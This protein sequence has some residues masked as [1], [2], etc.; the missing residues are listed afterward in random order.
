[1]DNSS[2]LGRRDF[3]RAGI[4]GAAG[5]AFDADAQGQP[6]RKVRYGVVGCGNRGRNSHLVYLKRYVPEVE[7]AALCDVTPEALQAAQALCPGAATYTDY[8]R[9]LSERKD[10]DAVIIAVPNYLHAEFSI[11]ALE[12]GKHVLVEKPMAIRLADCDRMIAA[13]NK[14][15]RA[16][17]IGIQCRYNQVFYEMAALIKQ[18]AIGE[19]KTVLTS[20]IRGDWNPRSWQYTDP[21]TGKRTNWRYMAKTVGSALLEDGSQE[22]DVACRLIGDK[23][24]RIYAQ[25]GKC[26]FK[27][28]D[29]ID[30]AGILIEFGNG[31]KV[32]YVYSTFT[33]GGYDEILRVWGTKAE[34][35]YSGSWYHNEGKGEILITRYEP[36]AKKERIPFAYLRPDEKSWDDG[37]PFDIAT[38]REHKEFLASVTKGAP[39]FCN[40][41]VARDITHLCL[42][43]ERS[44]RTG[45]VLSWD[46]VQEL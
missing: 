16:L 25:G 14:A 6:A 15:N 29:L 31:A 26:V 42:A 40:G 10:L 1:M 5:A 32:N 7:V 20:L 19:V 23:P 35:S 33:P 3:L 13:A 28:R 44:V 45:R 30:Q 8:R 37:K 12:T 41:Q 9:M 21:A 46:E 24:K 2:S 39:V 18:G 34:M 38:A 11:A 22:L 43:A 27:D 17:Q 4:A 36:R